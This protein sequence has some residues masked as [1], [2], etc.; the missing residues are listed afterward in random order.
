MNSKSNTLQP[1]WEALLDLR[2]RLS[3]VDAESLPL[4]QAHGRVLARDLLS[5][6]PSPATD[7]AAM[8]G[9]ALRLQDL[10]A[11]AIPVSEEALIGVAPPALSPGKA[12]RIM[13]GAPVPAG[14][15]LVLQREQLEEQPDHIKLR[16]TSETFLRSLAAGHNIRMAG[17][18]LPAGSPF[19]AAGMQ[20]GP[21]LLSAAAAFGHAQLHCK[22]QLR[23]TIL[24]TGNELADARSQELAPWQI[25]DSNG[26]LLT[27]LL[28]AL[29]YVK[30]VQATAIPDH[31]DAIARHIR[32]AWL[33]ADAVWLTGGVSAGDHD[34]VPAAIR[35]AGGTLCFHRLAIRPG[36]PLLGAVG[37]QG[38]LT[39]AFPG[40]P[41]AVACCAYLFGLPLLRRLAGLAEPLSAPALDPSDEDGTAANAAGRVVAVTHAHRHLPQVMVRGNARTLGLWSFPLVRR[42]GPNEV[43][44]ITSR[45]SGD[46]AALARSEGCVIL[47]PRHEGPGPWPLQ[48]WH[49]PN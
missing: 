12:C 5:D 43:E 4:E 29:P 49:H 19:A 48:L 7:V 16:D 18:N 23:V 32:N 8:D 6:R 35:A 3:P 21:Q 1:P 40:N 24:V 26:P 17:E 22:R 33:A 46:I 30:R 41:Q 2:A 37:P 11:A 25:R 36:K 34:H 13:T 28:A 9:Y 27:N 38:Q 14:A 20:L 45:G 31:P 15:E 39:L 44:L 42:L 47:P 10:G